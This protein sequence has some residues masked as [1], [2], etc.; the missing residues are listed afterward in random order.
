MLLMLIIKDKVMNNFQQFI[1]KI[2]K[3]EMIQ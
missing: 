2:I 1:G 3:K